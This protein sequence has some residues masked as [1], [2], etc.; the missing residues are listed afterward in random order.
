M[1]LAL[2]FLEALEQELDLQMWHRSPCGTSAI[3][4]C[5]SAGSLSKMEEISCC[6]SKLHPGREGH[7][8]AARFLPTY[9]GVVVLY[10]PHMH[11]LVTIH[12]RA[13]FCIYSC[14]L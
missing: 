2:S 12:N 6:S 9:A 3:M 11:F 7:C 10:R 8:C 14:N 13:Q 4:H 1:C 5:T